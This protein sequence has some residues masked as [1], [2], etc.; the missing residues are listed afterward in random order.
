MNALIH[1]YL[2]NPVLVNASKLVSAECVEWKGS[3]TDLCIA[4]DTDLKPNKLIAHLNA[5]IN[6]LRSKYGIEYKN[7]KRKV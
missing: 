3:P 1:C 2:R 4:I 5:H 7:R 6:E